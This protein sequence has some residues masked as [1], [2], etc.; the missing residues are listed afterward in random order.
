M[1]ITCTFP[2]FIVIFNSLWTTTSITME[3]GFSTHQIGFS[4]TV[5]YQIAET[6]ST[7]RLVGISPLIKMFF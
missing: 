2:R 3:I 4:Q 1:I 6:C 7:V 5:Y